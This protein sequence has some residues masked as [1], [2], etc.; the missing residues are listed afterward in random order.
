MKF[1]LLSFILLFF[2]TIMI[3]PQW[4]NQNIVPEGNHL[5]STFFIDHYTGWIAGSDGFLKKTTNAGLDW[6]NQN[7]G[8]S[9]TL[10]S[11]QFANQ[12][13]GWICGEEGLIL[14]TVDGGQHWYEQ[15]S[16]T[17]ELLTSL[18]FCSEMIGYVVGYNE[19]I[20][21]TTDGGLTWNIQNSGNVYDLFSVDF[22][23]PLLGFAVGGRDSTI[24]LKTTDG[25]L[26]WFSKNSLI[27]DAK[28]FNCIDFV[29]ANV[30]YLG[31]GKGGGTTTSGCIGKTTDGG[32][33]W[34][35]LNFSSPISKEDIIKHNLVDNPISDMQRGI[36]YI[37]FK[38]SQNGYAVGGTFDGWKRY[39]LKTTDAGNTWQTKYYYKEQT[40]LLS[41]FVNSNGQ[42][43]AVGCFGVIYRTTDDG[44]S[45]TQI[46]SGNE[47]VYTGDKIETIFMVNDSVGWAAGSR[48]GSQIYPMILK[49]TNGGKIWQTNFEST[50]SLFHNI[51]DIFFL[52]EN[53]G[54]AATG[55]IFN[56][57]E[58]Y[59]TTDGGENWSS[60]S[61]ASN[62]I[63]KIFF[64]TQNIGWGLKLSGTFSGIYKSVDGGN[65]W[66]LKNS[67]P[68]SSLYFKDIN[69]GWVVGLEGSILKSTD[70]GETWVSKTSG[71]SINLNSIK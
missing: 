52:N 8:T 65:T 53:I 25:G 3:Y 56:S 13:I 24:F 6:L 17:T 22:V 46:L 12:N 32:E 27:N 36:R 10:R 41:V 62:M 30:G 67:T 38:D 68:A 47:D 9:L 5:W 64:I 33:T 15:T 16:G 7:S 39:I 60:I 50:G 57:G 21:K 70:E 63:D 35:Y 59:K 71:T 66:L 37:Y 69:H 44:Y 18:N 51:S 11:V 48:Q 45:W 58:L 28:I 14:N 34:N 40:G 26:S 49:T 4:T 23:D 54:W 55:G 1:L 19:T 61:T 43:L 42:G 2:S 31:S 20:L 29:D